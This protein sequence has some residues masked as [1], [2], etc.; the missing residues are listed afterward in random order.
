MVGLYL[1]LLFD[2]CFANAVVGVALYG[3]TMYL[4]RKGRP[5]PGALQSTLLVQKWLGVAGLSLLVVLGFLPFDRS[6]MNDFFHS[7]NRVLHIF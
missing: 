1:T 2:I 7:L 4:Q 3:W 6:W 5:V